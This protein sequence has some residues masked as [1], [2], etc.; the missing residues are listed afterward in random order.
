MADEETDPLVTPP[1]SRGKVI[2]KEISVDLKHHFTEEELR[3]L[4]MEMARQEIRRNELKET[5]KNLGADYRSR[6]QD[7]EKIIKDDARKISNGFEYRPTECLK[8]MDFGVGIVT[9]IRKDTQ[10]VVEER[11]MTDA[12]KQVPLI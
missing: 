1:K 4:M 11:P 6:M 3:D 2:K 12:E 8:I 9:F 5:L 10:E 7:A